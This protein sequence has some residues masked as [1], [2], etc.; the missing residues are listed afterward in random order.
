MAPSSNSIASYVY[1]IMYFVGHNGPKHIFSTHSGLSYFL[2][3][4]YLNMDWI[5]MVKLRV[6]IYVYHVNIHIECDLATL[7]RCLIDIGCVPQDYIAGHNNTKGFHKH[8]Q[9]SF[10]FRQVYVG[11]KCVLSNGGTSRYC[12]ADRGRI[13]GMML[14]YRCGFYV[15]GLSYK[16]YLS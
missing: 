15:A 5:N 7:H 8:D 3:V 4:Q 13:E 16:F 10:P 11:N 9:Y 12:Q 6:N 1:T 2:R 14:Q